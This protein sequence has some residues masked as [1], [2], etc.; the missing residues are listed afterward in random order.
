MMN[1][2]S[3]DL[4]YVSTKIQLI[5]FSRFSINTRF[6]LYKFFRFPW[7]WRNVGESS[8]CSAPNYTPILLYVDNVASKYAKP[9]FTPIDKFRIRYPR[10]LFLYLII[11]LDFNLF[12]KTKLGSTSC[13]TNFS[14]KIVT[15][16]ATKQ[17]FNLPQTF[18]IFREIQ[19]NRDLTTSFRFPSKLDS[20]PFNL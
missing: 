19:P 5:F 13:F 3:Y 17:L 8:L 16:R 4:S 14:I 7:K 18:I 9:I 12:T 10:K 6:L 1:C 11:L 15:E 2:M 20:R